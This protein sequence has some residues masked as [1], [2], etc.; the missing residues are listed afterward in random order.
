MPLTSC[1]ASAS[2]IVTR[3]GADLCAAPESTGSEAIDASR[4]RRTT[5][6]MKHLPEAHQSIAPDRTVVI[7]LAAIVLTMAVVW[8]VVS[9]AD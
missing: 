4:D 6:D 8:V 9:L 7:I 3:M 5:V 1:A 2:S